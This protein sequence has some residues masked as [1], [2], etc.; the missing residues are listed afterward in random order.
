MRT[1]DPGAQSLRERA[2]QEDRARAVPRGS[3]AG[4]CAR[5]SQLV[6]GRVGGLRA[7][8]RG[9]RS[10]SARCSAAETS[11]WRGI[12]RFGA[13]TNIGTWRG[14]VHRILSPRISLGI[15]TGLWSHHYDSG[16]LVLETVDERTLRMRLCDFPH[17]HLTHCL[18]IAGWIER[19]IELGRPDRSTC[20]TACRLDGAPACGTPR[21][22]G[23]RRNSRRPRVVL[24]ESAPGTGTE[25]SRA[26]RTIHPRMRSG[27]V[28][29]PPGGPR[30]RGLNQGL[31]MPHVRA[32]VSCRDP[33]SGS[34]SPSRPR[35]WRLRAPPRAAHVEGADVADYASSGA[36]CRFSSRTARRARPIRGSG[37]WTGRQ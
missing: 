17:P 24:V 20:A 18:A 22:L 34:S 36:A 33:P 9:E 37:S 19:T 27:S 26:A 7:L 2:L 1:D 3:V 8:H 5:R 30:L 29:M 16:R 6:G 21:V 31:S 15:A 35:A 4:I 10:S 23:V 11:R 12:G 14:I 25:P 13:E 32:R 28:R